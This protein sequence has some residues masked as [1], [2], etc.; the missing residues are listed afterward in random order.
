MINVRRIKQV[1]HYGWVHAEDAAMLSHDA[2]TPKCHGRIW[3]YIDILICFYKYRM[4]SN[5]YLGEKFYEKTK[6]ERTPIANKYK[7]E[8]KKRDLWDRGYADNL[9]FFIKYGN[10]KY[11]HP[12]SKHIRQQAYAVRYHAGKNLMVEENVYVARHHYLEG[13][14]QIG[15]NVYLAANSHL[16]YSGGLSIEDNARI[17]NGVII[18][19]H[20]HT[21]H[22]DY[23]ISKKDIVA[24]SLVIKQGAVIGVRSVI[25]PGCNYIGIHARIGAGAVVTKDV[26]DY[27]I[28]AGVPAKIIKIMEH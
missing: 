26:P 25:L 10:V 11:S 2:E 27:A 4:W 15:D 6:E 5:Q 28:V 24:S 22:S 12:S 9:K 8:G 19:T 16:D 7:E 3:F 21:Y 23:R 20:S 17:T 18:E 13:N 14:I 1:L